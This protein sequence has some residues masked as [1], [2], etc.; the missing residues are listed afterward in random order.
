M[1]G[2]PYFSVK[3]SG[4][5]YQPMAEFRGGDVKASLRYPADYEPFGHSSFAASTLSKTRR[6]EVKDRPASSHSTEPARAGGRLV[7]VPSMLTANGIEAG[8]V[9]FEHFLQIPVGDD[10]VIHDEEDFAEKRRQLLLD[11]EWLGLRELELEYL[12]DRLTEMGE[13]LAAIK[14]HQWEDPE[15][16]NRSKVEEMGEE[17]FEKLLS[18][19]LGATGAGTGSV[20]LKTQIAALQ[21]VLNTKNLW[22]DFSRVEWRARVGQLLWAP[23]DLDFEQAAAGKMPS[24][25]DV[26]LLQITLA[27]E[28]YMRLLAQEALSSS[29]PPMISQDD[30]DLLQ[31]QRSDK[32]KWDLVLAERFLDNLNISAKAR[33]TDEEKKASR[34][35]FFSAITFFSAKEAIDE[36]EESVQPVVFAKHETEQ[37]EGLAYFADRIQWPHAADMKIEL[38]SKLSKSTRERPVSTAAS[39]YAT[40]LSSPKLFPSTPGTNRNSFFGFSEQPARPGFSRKN[41]G[42]SI[43]LWPARNIAGNV[44]SFEIGG[45]LSRSW[46]SGLVMPGEAARH[47]LISTLLENSPQAIA[48]LGEEA[49]L[50]GGFVYEGRGFW[51]KSCVVGK[52]MAAR[53]GAKECMG[54]VSMPMDRSM[55]DGWVGVDVREPP[56]PPMPRILAADSIVKDSDPIRGHRIDSLQ[57]G[58]LARPADGP[59]VL[60]NEVRFDGITF[61]NPAKAADGEETSTASLTFSSPINTKLASLTVPLTYDVHFISSYPCHP[62]S[63]RPRTLSRPFTPSPQLACE[64]KPSTPKQQTQ[65]SASPSFAT[66]ISRKQSP[67][68]DPNST[69]TTSFHAMEKELPSVPAHPIHIDYQFT[70]VPVATLLSM[71]AT[72]RPR[73]LSEPSQ[74]K[75]SVAGPTASE[76]AEEVVILDCR[77]DE[78]LELLARAWC[79][80]VGENALIG[81]SGRTCLGCCVREARALAVGV[82]IRI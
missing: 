32:V 18:S 60:G 66:P 16:W 8:A 81:K 9:G 70:I 47:F 28:L 44:E 26:L 45:W 64:A 24:E 63:A 69:S 39:I 50:Y 52:V 4:D 40:P 12:I 6:D 53:K 38:E 23:E 42:Q 78:D 14:Q 82:V 2:A 35:S 57:A 5:V 7:E 25:R 80:K 11:P 17:L 73:A 15:P 51:S 56:E 19:E 58:D 41:T 36:T 10:L 49:N 79:A 43:A 71:P 67:P 29:F 76:V 61:S 3:K 31:C 20:T 74:R 62:Q 34:N 75:L 13:L 54:W 72:Q 21:R 1:L 77:G 33:R 22:H 46:L 55:D 27:A 30:V 48:A 59:L 37:L 68:C 65:H